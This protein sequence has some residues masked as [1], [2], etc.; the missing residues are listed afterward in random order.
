MTTISETAICLRRW[1]FPETSQVAAV[2]VR[3]TG[4]VRGLAKGARRPKARYSGGF[5]GLTRGWLVA[6]LKP[7]RDLA[8]L[9]EWHLETVY[10]AIR[11]DLAAHRAGM[12]MADVVL[13]LTNPEDPHPVLFD[14]LV[15]GLEAM[16]EGEPPG[17]AL[18]R[19]QLDALRDLGFAPVLDRDAETG[20]ATHPDAPTLAFGPGAGGI[21]DDDGRPDR[22]RVRR[23]TVELLRRSADGG[24]I[25]GDPATI[26]RANRLLAT[27]AQ[28]VAGSA[29]ASLRWTFPDLPEPASPGDARAPA[30]RASR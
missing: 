21:V 17:S 25:A 24:G 20:E 29:L 3:E 9:T 2:L 14:A 13:T 19:F 10:R 27:F 5:D 8:I 4:V 30:P 28:W 26:H 23:E 1:P 7:G 22:W 6:I 15:A 11:A 16:D 18:L 12:H